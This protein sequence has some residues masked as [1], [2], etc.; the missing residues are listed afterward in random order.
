MQTRQALILRQ[1]TPLTSGLRQATSP[2]AAAHEG[3]RRWQLALSKRGPSDARVSLDPR[4]MVRVSG[5]DGVLVVRAYGGGSVVLLAWNVADEVLRGRI[6]HFTLERAPAA[7]ADPEWFSFGDRAAQHKL[8]RYHYC[9]YTAVWD[10]RY[11]YRV[12]GWGAD[13]GAPLCSVSVE[14]ALPDPFSLTHG[15]FF[16]RGAAGSQAYERN[17][18]TQTAPLDPEARHLEPERWQWLSRGLEEALFRFVEQARDASHSLH[19]AAY[20]LTHQPFLELLKRKAEQGVVVRVVHDQK[21]GKDTTADAQVWL[22]TLAL[23]RP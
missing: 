19:V 3:W 18:P 12:R 9:D 13:G 21:E 15:V 6:A 2:S 17:F 4:Q 5:S 16:N 20:E 23:V 14:L 10:T 1:P 8:R 22:Q 11:T 7:T